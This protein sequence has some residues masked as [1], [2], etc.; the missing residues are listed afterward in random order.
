M[1]KLRVASKINEVI[2]L[3]KL[4]KEQKHLGNTLNPSLIIGKNGLNEGSIKIIKDLI[5][6]NSIVKI[7][8]LPA[9]IDEKDKKQVAKDFADKCNAK[10]VELK[11][12]TILL[13]RK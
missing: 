9:F 10:L 6:K 4:T 8:I 13:A 1:L 5:R 11:G 3:D 2:K 12:F 7:K